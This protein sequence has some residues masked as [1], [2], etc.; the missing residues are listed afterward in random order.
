RD[1]SQQD[2]PGPIQQGL[3][4]SEDDKRNRGPAPGRSVVRRQDVINGARTTVAHGQASTDKP[5]RR[6]DQRS[7]HHERRVEG[8]SQP[9]TCDG[10]KANQRPVPYHAVWHKRRSYTTKGPHYRA[11]NPHERQDRYQRESDKESAPELR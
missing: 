5:Q 10:Q 9:H 2:D 4:G 3:G 6:A 7:Y 8:P 1:P 11:A